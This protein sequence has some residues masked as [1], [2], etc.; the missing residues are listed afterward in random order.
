[1]SE[2]KAVSR[3]HPKP[4]NWYQHYFAAVTEPDNDRALLKIQ[5]AQQAMQERLVQLRRLPHPESS[6]LQDLNSALTYLWVLLPY[7]DCSLET[8]RWQ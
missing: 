2:V 5:R 6:E 8:P 7:L 3:T 1:M 4:S